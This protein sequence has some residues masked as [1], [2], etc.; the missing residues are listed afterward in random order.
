MNRESYTSG[1]WA[2]RFGYGVCPN[3]MNLIADGIMLYTEDEEV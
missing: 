2:E 3:S 1:A